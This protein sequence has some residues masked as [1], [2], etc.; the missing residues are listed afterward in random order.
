MFDAVE[1]ENSRKD[2]LSNPNVRL[3]VVKSVV[4]VE[5]D[6]K[7]ITL[8]CQGKNYR[9]T[10]LDPFF[11][12]EDLALISD[13]TDEPVTVRIDICS[14]DIFRLRLVRGSKL[15]ARKKPMVVNEFEIPVNYCIKDDDSTITIE[16]TSLQIRINKIEWNLSVYSSNNELIFS[17]YTKDEHSIS[18]IVKEQ[19]ERYRDSYSGFECYPFGIAE[20]LETGNQIATDSIVLGYDEHFYGFGEK[21]G[22]LDKLGQEVMLWHFDSLGVST[23]KSYKNI[24]FYMSTHGYGIYA[25]TCTKSK[26]SMGN[27]FYK[28]YQITVNEGELDY[29]F[30]YG[31]S[32]KKI[33]SGYTDITGK[34]PMVPKWSFG[35]WM[36]K[37]TYRTQ[38]ELLDVAKMMRAKKIPCDVVHLDVGWFEKEWMCDFEFCK[39]RFP[40]VEQMTEELNKMGYHLSM[41]QLPYIKKENKLYAFA[42]DQGYFAKNIDGTISTREADGVIDFSNPKAV[43]WYKGL[44]GNLLEI[45]TSVIKADFGESTEE[46][47]L[48]QEYTGKEMHNLYPLLYQKTVF[49]KTIEVTGEGILWGR[50]AYA[51]SQKY[52]IHWGGDAG[53]DFTSLYNSIRGG[54]SLGLSGFTFWSHDVGGYYCDVDPEVYIRW[55]QV[56]MFSSHMRMHGTTSRE[57]WTFGHEVERIFMKYAKL[58]YKLMPY[59]YST[60]HKSCKQ[61]LPMMRAM[62]LEFENDPTTRNIDDQYMFG[63]SLLVAPILNHEGK[64]KVYLPQGIRWYDYWTKEYMEG[65]QWINICAPLDVLP[66]Y[67]REGA[68]IPMGEEMNYVD[69]K[70]S[71]ILT[72]DLYPGFDSHSCFTILDDKLSTEISLDSSNDKI[73]I[74]I[75]QIEKEIKIIVNNV[76]NVDQVVCNNNKL[77]KY[78]EGDELRINVYRL[79]NNC[80]EIL[81]LPNNTQTRLTIYRDSQLGKEFCN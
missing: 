56:G 6:I 75:S 79:K 28:A 63:D 59:I 1:Y 19:D 55:S 57:P 35:L 29:Y 76:E 36:S 24:P 69:E 51:G 3:T 60:A 18:H 9:K 44:I 73:Q 65:K 68:I 12:Q 21:F 40:N 16:T 37:N 34:S 80:V 38:Q 14:K 5:K 30:I 72:L 66:L 2:F 81:I 52:P 17:Q 70:E 7:G 67:I 15:E 25:N 50:S 10:F 46:D 8:L 42:C 39:E 4:A 77:S 22:P 23:S 78:N 26:Y 47:A 71:K 48:Y 62:I 54:L 33:L 27:Y 49:E 64:R 45:G 43:D 74:N 31:P 32:L 20:E 58:R 41:W 11:I 53:T 13:G 61:S